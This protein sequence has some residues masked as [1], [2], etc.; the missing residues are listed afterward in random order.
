MSGADSPATT[1][2][3][4]DRL[5]ALLLVNRLVDVD[6]KPLT[7][8]E[9]WPL[10][11]EVERPGALLGLDVD[12]LADLSAVSAVGADRVRTLLDAATALAFALDELDQSGIWTCSP[13]DDDYP[14]RFRVRLGRG[15]PPV[16]FG[17]GPH[18]LLGGGGLAIVGSRGVDAAGGEVAREAA[19]LAART[20]RS[21][22]SGG[23]RGVDQLAMAAA[24]EVEGAVVGVLAD[25]LVKALRSPENR[26]AVGEGRVCLCTP[27]K[28]TAGFSAANA[29]GRNKLVYALADLTLVV[30]TDEGSGGTWA[31][32]TEALRRGYGR[33]AVWRGDGEGPGNGALVE[34]GAVEVRSLE[35]LEALLAEPSDGPPAAESDVSGVSGVSADPVAEQ[36]DLG[37]G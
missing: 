7:A 9:L 24:D 16:L 31:G 4:D 14:E 13:F 3:T 8:T 23:A 27:Y 34:K 37:L 19:R 1:A 12:A 21:V 22:I 25:A 10:L 6:A 20:G 36:L 35:E 18:S 17:A 11:D 15:A 2:T 32:A 28:P 5:A 33:V 26:R 30:A 29:M